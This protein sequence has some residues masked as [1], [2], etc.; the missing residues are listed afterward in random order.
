M[1]QFSRVIQL[2]S[3]IKLVRGFSAILEVA[4]KLSCAQR[5]NAVIAHRC[6]KA[7]FAVAVSAIKPVKECVRVEC[8]FLRCI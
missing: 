1:R 4:D 6:V 8:K 2:L 3:D 7:G 5:R